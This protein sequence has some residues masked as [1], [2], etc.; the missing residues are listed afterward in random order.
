MASNY[1]KYSNVRVYRRYCFGAIFSGL[2][3]LCVAGAVAVL[4]L[5]PLVFF[6]QEGSDPTYLTGL[7][8]VLYSVRNIPFLK[9]ENLPEMLNYDKFVIFNEIGRAHV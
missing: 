8:F 2:L 6:V 3:S 5:F 7:Q 4:L 1:S 9:F